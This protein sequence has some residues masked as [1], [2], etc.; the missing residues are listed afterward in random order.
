MLIIDDDLHLRKPVLTYTQMENYQC[1][2]AENGERALAQAGVPL[3]KSI[4]YQ[5]LFQK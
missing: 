2:G 4:L 3:K 5:F 1:R